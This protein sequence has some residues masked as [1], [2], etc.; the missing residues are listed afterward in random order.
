MNI[1]V[2]TRFLIKDQLEGYGYFT[3]E[4][5]K[6]LTRKFPQHQFYFLFDRAYDPDFV[7][8]PN[9]HPIVLSPP[10]RHPLLWKLWYEVRVPAVLKKLKADIFVSPDGISSLSARVPQC[11][12]LHDI[13]IIHFPQDYKRSH[14]LFY[15]RNIPRMIRKAAIVCTVSGFSRQ[16]IIRTYGTPMEKIDLVYSAAKSIF[17][18]AKVEEA[19]KTRQEFTSGKQYFI[20]AGSI[21][22]RKNLLQL[23]KAFSLFKKRMQSNMKLVLVGRML[24]KT[25][26]FLESLKTYK[27]RDDVVITGYVDESRLVR[28]MGA[29]YALVYPSAF[30]GFGVPVLEAMRSE[31]P[32]LTS[33]NSSMQEIAGDAALYFDP[34][35][36]QDIAE[37]M[38]RIYKDEDLRSRLIAKGKE[39]ESQY[40]WERT[41]LLLWE[42]MMKVVDS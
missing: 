33:L 35:N 30:E 42:S 20:Y 27:Y 31:V 5:F 9:V 15:K 2:N 8:A 28:L 26:Q 41:A 12:V 32:V 6:V 13:G 40:S 34:T 22:P 23:L 17:R 38:M 24:W 37:S 19:E 1:V 16:D 36:H 21:H 10:A 39:V 29:S 3:L 4:V 11:L 25:G 18:P 7:L 14:Y